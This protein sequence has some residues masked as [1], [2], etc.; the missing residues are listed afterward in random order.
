MN[1]VTIVFDYCT[2]VILYTR[3]LVM[4]VGEEEIYDHFFKVE[5]EVVQSF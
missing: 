2:N 3:S 5:E 4:D 1:L